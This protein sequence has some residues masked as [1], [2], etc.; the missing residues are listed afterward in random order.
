MLGQLLRFQPLDV[1]GA[2]QISL[3]LWAKRREVRFAQHGI[4]R[5]VVNA[6]GGFR[7]VAHLVDSGPV[8]PLDA[9]LAHVIAGQREL[10]VGGAAN[11]GRAAQAA[12]LGQ[13]DVADLAHPEHVGR[14]RSAAPRKQAEHLLHQ[15]HPCPGPGQR[16]AVQ[17]VVE[18]L[19][20]D[21]P[22]PELHYRGQRIAAG[23]PQRDG[24]RGGRLQHVV[25]REVDVAGVAPLVAQQRQQDG[26][27]QAG[28]V[29][30]QRL[31]RIGL[32]DLADG[33]AA[34][35]AGVPFVEPQRRDL[36]VGNE[37]H[38]AAVANVGRQVAGRRLA[39]IRRAVEHDGR[40][41]GERYAAQ[42]GRRNAFDV[43]RGAVALAERLA[44]IH[45]VSQKIRA[46]VSELQRRLLLPVAGRRDQKHLL[47]IAEPHREPIMVVAGQGVRIDLDT[48][49]G[50]LGHF[51]SLDQIDRGRLARFQ[52][53]LARLARL[54][55]R[56]DP[57]I[58]ALRPARMI[59]H[60]GRHP[61][62][63]A[64]VDLLR[65]EPDVLQGQVV[66]LR[67]RRIDQHQLDLSPVEII[68]KG[69]RGIL[70]A[71]A[72][73]FFQIRLEMRLLMVRKD[74]HAGIGVAAAGQLADD[75]SQ[76]GHQRPA[77][78]VAHLESRGLPA[79]LFPVLQVAGLRGHAVADEDQVHAV[80]R[81]H[82]V[83]HRKDIR[84]APLEEV[85]VGI[86]LP[87][88]AQ[89]L[90]E[91][92]GHGP[93]ARPVVLDRQPRHEQYEQRQQEQPQQQLQPIARHRRER[94]GR[95]LHVEELERG[96]HLRAEPL[97]LDQVQDDRHGQA[98]KPQEHPGVQHHRAL[99]I[100]RRTRCIAS[101]RPRSAALSSRR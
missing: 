59:A 24:G 27:D 43:D 66:G 5:Q 68:A 77:A 55:A 75:A 73:G 99:R 1:H 41:H 96:E 19:H 98:G 20:E 54:L 53:Q 9:D 28:L 26:I 46:A 15:R 62:A 34:Q 67:R 6:G 10:R 50:V 45:R 80:L 82:F 38:A 25:P 74:E 17:L 78:A 29:A 76:L 18:K 101:R 30:P 61:A 56:G 60:D 23:G 39:E 87:L 64:Q 71:D 97:P 52:P 32:L 89:R 63:S 49:G 3:G 94:I 14:R 8:E 84:P 92:D 44:G 40:I 72:A 33:Q 11:V 83:D 86:H 88:H 37:P 21:S 12:Q 69:Q 93:R 70:V 91:H 2:E 65:H 42:H 22:T 58:R 48:A 31:D 13:Q 16:A 51:E 100:A 90:V 57:D 85:L 7:R 79:K 47:A 95:V 4:H 36:A 81:P 35:Q